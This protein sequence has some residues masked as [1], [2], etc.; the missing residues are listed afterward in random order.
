MAI[1][2]WGTF[3]VRDHLAERAFVADV[4]LYDRLVIPTLP[5]GSPEGE[6]PPQWG[7]SRQ[8]TLLGDLGE[9]AIPIPWDAQRREEWQKRFDDANGVQRRIAHAQQ[10][11][12]VTRDVASAR[13]QDVVADGYNITRRLLQDFAN[14]E[15]DDK[16][17]RK[18][19]VTKKARPGAKLEAVSAYTSFDAFAADVPQTVVTQETRENNSGKD[20]PLPVTSVFGWKFFVPDTED[21]GEYGDRKL[22]EKAVKLATKT[23]FIEM[24]QNFYGWWSDVCS[25]RLAPEDA[26]ED[27]EMRIDEY[28]KLLEGQGWKT[29]A[30]Y[31]IKVADAFSGGLGLVNEVVGAGAEVL[32]GNAD[33]I[34]DEMLAKEK[35][36]QRLKVAA[37]FHDAR[38][39]FGWKAK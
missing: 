1:E 10:A 39:R 6:W 23:E 27:M 22:L 21:K 11:D 2:L 24:R 34:A 37:I 14:K 25:N 16:L 26:K 3:S 29:V 38:S 12:A 7:L 8:K 31:A 19:R 18:L 20:F 9:L 17:F 35:A 15:A 33:I 36:P 4:L 28:N 32:L 5:E 13:Q 30:R